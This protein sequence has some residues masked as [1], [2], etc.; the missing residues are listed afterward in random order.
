MYVH[1]FCLVSFHLCSFTFST[2]RICYYPVLP[3]V[4]LFLSRFRVSFIQYVHSINWF[5]LIIILI[6]V[7]NCSNHHHNCYHLMLCP[8][9][10]DLSLSSFLSL[11][12][13]QVLQQGVSGCS[14]TYSQEGVYSCSHTS[15]PALC[16]N[17]C[18]LSWLSYVP[19][20][21]ACWC[22]QSKHT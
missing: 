12:S 14:L 18:S 5:I 20:W 22:Y 6:L 9:F 2:F 10:Q 3:F 7:I 19:F 15:Y 17:I 11:W 1:C 16:H 21:Q 13:C 8:V 4:I